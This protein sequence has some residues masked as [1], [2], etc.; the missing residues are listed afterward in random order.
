MPIDTYFVK[1]EAGDI[2]MPGAPILHFS[3]LVVVG[4]GL[5]SGHVK[6]TQALPPPHGA[7]ALPVSGH[8]HALGLPPAHNVV[9]LEGT[10]LQSFLP[11]AIGSILEHFSSVFSVNGEW[12]G[13]GSFTYGGHT[14]ANVPVKK[15]P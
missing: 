4:S 14:V 2:G 11:P 7:I 3:L 12:N 6:I 8:I 1:G 9:T 10:Y 5:V 13:H 15:L